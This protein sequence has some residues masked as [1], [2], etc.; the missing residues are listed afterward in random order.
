MATKITFDNKEDY[1]VSILPEIQKVTAADMNQIK[2][3]VN[4]NADLL[5][6][7]VIWVNGLNDLPPPFINIGTGET[8]Y[9]LENKTYIING[10]LDLLGGYFL[11]NE[12]TA[13]LGTSSELSFLTS[14][15]LTF[16]AIIKAS[17][18]IT[19]KNITIRDV[20]EGVLIDRDGSNPLACDWEYVNFENIPTVGMVINCDNFIFN[21]GAFLNSN[22]LSYEGEIGTISF[23]KCLFRSNG[24]AT[25]IIEVKDTAEILRRFR[26]TFS[27]FVVVDDS[28]G[29]FFND[30]AI[31]PVESY[32]LK[33]INFSGN[34]TYLDDVTSL[35]NKALFKDNVGITNT[36]VNGQLFMQNNATATTITNTSDFFKIEG[37]TTA[38]PDNAKFIHSNNRLTCDAVIERKYLVQAV[39][40][41]TSSATNVCEFGFYDSQLANVRTPSKTKATANAAGREENVPLACV[42]KM[43]QG[44]FIEIHCRNTSA[45]NDI[46]VESMNFIITEIS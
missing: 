8:A 27:S 12:V 14:T 37:T 22:G 45:A 41:F 20:E 25:P 2:T 16:G 44:D 29:I 35:S 10:T 43:K 9:P 40:T 26:I 30:D 33:D 36:A 6:E 3:A 18:S 28:I 24:E 19:I 39:V 46:T 1:T 38:S 21:T 4:D 11:C 15:G 31:V 13:I 5:P 32:I 7:N 42:V 17:K 34:G 23:D